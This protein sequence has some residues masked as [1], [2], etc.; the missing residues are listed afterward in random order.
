MQDRKQIKHLSFNNSCATNF[1]RW[2]FQPTIELLFQISKK[3]HPQVE[4]SNQK[5]RVVSHCPLTTH[6][7]HNALALKIGTHRREEYSIITR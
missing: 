3:I 2:A 7:T 6:K 1:L 4:A 5:K